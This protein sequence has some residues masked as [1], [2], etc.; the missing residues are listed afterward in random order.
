MTTTTIRTTI[1]V[2][3]EVELN[4]VCDLFVAVFDSGASNSWIH[5]CEYE[6]PEDPDWSWCSQEEREDWAVARLVYVAPM[7]GG[8]IDFVLFNEDETGPGKTVRIGRDE[9]LK[10]LATMAKESPKHFMDFVNEDD[11]AITSDVFAQY[12]VLGEAPY[13]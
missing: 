5:G 2:E 7:C 8:H 4:R 11:D 3:V 9:F 1:R 10:G 6:M 13:G 12:C